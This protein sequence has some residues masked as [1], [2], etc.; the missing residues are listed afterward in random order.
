MPFDLK[1]VNNAWEEYQESEKKDCE[2]IN[3][4]IKSIR[5]NNPMQIPEPLKHEYSGCLSLE[6]NKKD[7][8][9]Y[10]ILENTVEVLSCRGHY[11]DK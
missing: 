9:I 8:L 1:F 11:D 3:R 5:R 7:R 4:L 2:K 10:R 6:I